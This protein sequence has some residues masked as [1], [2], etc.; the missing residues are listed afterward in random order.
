MKWAF[1]KKL[2]GSLCFNHKYCMGDRV[3][4][5]SGFYEGQSGKMHSDKLLGMYGVMLDDF[6]RLVFIQPIHLRPEEAGE[7][8]D[9]QT[10]WE[11]LDW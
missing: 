10:H 6:E 5:Q 11:R 8:D 1:G 2:A 3:I 4:V 7:D 9:D